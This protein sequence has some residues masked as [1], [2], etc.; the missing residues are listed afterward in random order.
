[1]TSDPVQSLVAELIERIEREP[2]FDPAA[3]I[4]AQREHGPALRSRLDKLQ[5]AGLLSPRGKRQ[6]LIEEL[7][8]RF[9]LQGTPSSVRPGPEQATDE[10]T[11]ARVVAG[12]YRILS[13]V[14]RGGMGRVF[15]ALDIELGRELAL[16]VIDRSHGAAPAAAR[17]FLERFLNEAQLTSQL[18]H[19]SIVPL[20][21]IGLDADGQP[22]YTMKLVEGRTL[23]SALDGWHD[24]LAA[25]RPLPVREL[26]RILLQV[27]D[28]LSFAHERGVIHRDVKPA[29]VMIG[30]FGEV[31]LMDWGLAKSIG[32]PE[33]SVATAAS[34]TRPGSPTLAGQVL[35]T[36]SHMAPEQ[37]RGERVD[38]RADVY[39]VGALLFH[40]LYGV[41]PNEGLSPR[42][43][44]VPP[45]LRAVCR[46]ALHFTLA[47]RYPTVHALAED[48]RAFLDARGS[49]T[50][51]D[52]PLRRLTKWTRRNPAVATGWA[53][54]AV[55]TALVATALV[56]L[57]G[58]EERAE[59]ER[60]RSIVS[61]LS[62]FLRNSKPKDEA[63]DLDTPDRIPDVCTD[64]LA[65]FAATGF[66]LDGPEPLGD[67]LA[68][69]E[70]VR[71]LDPGLHEELVG[72]I[73]SLINLLTRAQLDSVRRFCAGT[74]DREISRK[75]ELWQGWCGEYS[76]LLTA[77][78]RLQEL[79][80]GLQE[81]PW[82]ARVIRAYRARFEQRE[83]W[84][85]EILDETP[86]SGED[87]AYLAMLLV[88]SEGEGEGDRADARAMELLQAAGP[89]IEDS[90]WA[91][92]ILGELGSRVELGGP[93][94]GA[95][96]NTFAAVSLNPRSFRA[97]SNLGAGLVKAQNF[98][99]AV[100]AL[101]RAF[102]LRPDD[103]TTRANLVKALTNL[104]LSIADHSTAYFRAQSLV[105]STNRVERE[106]LGSAALHARN[107]TIELYERALELVPK[108]VP[109]HV[110]LANALGDA[111]EA[112]PH[113][114]AALE[115][116]P[117]HFAT[118]WSYS[119][120]LH[121]AGRH[122]ERVH[123]LEALH[124][125]QPARA[126]VTAILGQARHEWGSRRVAQGDVE[127]G[128]ALIESGLAAFELACRLD[129]NDFFSEQC[130]GLALAELGRSAEA[131]E[132]LERSI[133]R[134][135]EDGTSPDPK[136]TPAEHAKR[137]RQLTTHGILLPTAT[138]SWSED[139][140]AHLAELLERARSFLDFLEE[141]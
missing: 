132:C 137:L 98:E 119:D 57:R 18:E 84:P 117:C 36:P 47:K 91:Q 2:D 86:E 122:A 128:R 16:K 17:T 80:L 8:T 109:A 43:K 136:A 27:C 134:R 105:P 49:P 37:A 123:C 42:S 131:L 24:D 92:L 13:E 127:D 12:R 30:R 21:D 106:R 126:D 141:E 4:A 59:H 95:I 31:H 68:R 90:Y 45:E 11:P 14:G 76:H 25:G 41:P 60:E 66:P 115:I 53:A 46:R 3:F 97:W 55:L 88:G 81:D 5:R 9:E 48:L 19:P 102:E 108:D 67:L 1:M 124:E 72:S 61:R 101:E 22:Y 93:Q 64:R 83:P 62:T 113:Y 118:L 114:R 69:I 52:G 130:C 32:A 85:E 20:H 99:I 107:R 44:H 63:Y 78:P 111:P 135:I 10:L 23:E 120:W 103:P 110:N 6:S 75:R 50:W 33:P 133:D 116:D 129:P 26:L 58:A 28:A 104:G 139:E 96:E 121:G 138:R 35:G 112:E 34:P 56:V 140:R 70:G 38:Q 71:D 74:L 79:Q 125:C 39:G 54:G 94:P 29:N 100:F 51:S 73:D 77:L 82:R 87:M 89:A 40:A 15:R 65:G 7:R